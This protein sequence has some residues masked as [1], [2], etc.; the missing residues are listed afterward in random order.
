[1]MEENIK[2]NQNPNQTDSEQIELEPPSR[3]NINRYHD[4]EG[5]SVA[6]MD[7]GFW[8]LSNKSNLVSAFYFSLLLFAFA[9]WSF[10]FFQFFSYLVY[11][12]TEN[13]D[14]TREVMYNKLPSIDFYYEKAATNLMYYPVQVIPGNGTKSD[15][16][17]QIKNP[18]K[19]HYA[20]F[21][22]TFKNNGEILTEE[23]GFIL[24]DETKHLLSLGYELDSALGGLQVE[25]SDIQFY[26]TNPHLFGDWDNFEETHMDVDIFNVVFAPSGNTQL[27][28]RIPLSTLSFDIS[29]NSSYNYWNF[30]VI[31]SLYNYSDII[32]VSK[33]NVNDFESETERN[34]SFAWPGKL[35]A[36]TDIKI[37]PDVNITQ[38]DI[39]KRFDTPVGEFR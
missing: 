7:F 18:N 16:L 25:V 36:V 32:S 29:N 30:P 23:D 2:N 17:T 5:L 19:D 24:P 6:K 15:L 3:V 38:D 22:Y 10:F 14:V 28:E 4:P 8:I 31:I 35:K 21:K 11:G 39:Y 1:M 37:E 26:R 9:S 34:V 27:S 12:I 20:T 13:R 33:Y